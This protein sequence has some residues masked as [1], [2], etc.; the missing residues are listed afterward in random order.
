MGNPFIKLHAAVLLAGLTG[1]LGKLIQL[2]EGPLVWYRMLLTWLLMGA[3]LAVAG[4]FPRLSVRE[5][6]RIALAGCL[7][8]IHWI[9]FYGSIK[10]ANVSIAVV[11][12]ALMGFFTAVLEPIANKK[13]ISLREVGFS[14]VAVF[15]ITLIFHFDIRYRWGIVLGVL[16]SLFAALFTIRVKTVGVSHKA[17]TMLFYQ[18]A[19][20]WLFLTL[21][22]P[23]HFVLLPDMPLVPGVTDAAYLFILASVCTVGLFILQIQA[24]KEISAF[25]VNLSFNL[26]PVYSIALA[27]LFLGEGKELTPTFFAGLGLIGLSVFLQSARVALASKRHV[28]EKNP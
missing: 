12:F 18:M 25:T 14:L 27:I 3:G 13:T 21:C 16:S 22:A 17:S 9:F 19:G 24:L 20:G 4:S 5:A 1:I 8:A 15:G 28:G 23:L 11:C 6:G 26:E 10:A 2:S 7:M